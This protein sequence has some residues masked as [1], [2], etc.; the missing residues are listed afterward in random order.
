M[1]DPSIQNQIKCEFST[2]EK[3]EQVTVLYACESGSRAWGFE[4]Q[5]SDYDV[6]FIYLRKTEWY[7]SLTPGR[8]VIERPISDDLDIAGWDFPKAMKLMRKSNPPLLEWLQSPIVYH[9]SFDFRERIHEEADHCFSPIASMYHYRRMAENNFRKY[10]LKDRVNLK[11]YFYVLRPV[12]ACLWIERGHGIVPIL[13]QSLV[14]RVIDESA[15]REAI[16]ELIQI[17]KS[18]SEM[19]DSE[20]HPV[21]QPFLESELARLD[22]SLQRPAD[23]L[24]EQRLDRLFRDFLQ[25]VNGTRW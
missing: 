15:L 3:D 2:I 24:P 16:M 1:I 12:M 18:G 23:P 9:E 19:D 10:L 8:D 17:K 4:S 11:K 14:D 13:F 22:A 7:L 5:D 25:E 20:K 6:R 21:I